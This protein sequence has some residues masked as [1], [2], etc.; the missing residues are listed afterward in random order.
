MLGGPG[1]RSWGPAFWRT[2]PTRVS[3]QA[4]QSPR[5]PRAACAWSMSRRRSVPS[6]GPGGCWPP[7]STASSWP[8]GLGTRP[9]PGR[10]RCV[11]RAPWRQGTRV[12]LPAWSQAPCAC[13]PRIRPP[14][15]R[16]VGASAH[17][18]QCCAPAQALRGRS[19]RSLRFSL[20]SQPEAGLSGSL[21]RAQD[22]LA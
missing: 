13:S 7:W 21:S 14:I 6:A 2:L 4:R 5:M 11:C 9:S 10:R 19:Q 18:W 8:R 20:G 3:P 1:D 15:G 12:A 22:L 17:A 16:V